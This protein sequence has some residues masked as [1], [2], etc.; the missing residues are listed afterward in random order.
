MG[1]CLGRKLKARRERCDRARYKL[2]SEVD[3]AVAIARTQLHV[4][5]FLQKIADS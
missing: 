5:A 2:I 1:V 3:N 4:F